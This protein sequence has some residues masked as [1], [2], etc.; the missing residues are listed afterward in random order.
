MGSGCICGKKTTHTPGGNMEFLQPGEVR[1]KNLSNSMPKRIKMV[2][3]ATE[4]AT[5]YITY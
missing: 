4:D 3:E 1:V 2:I 5:K